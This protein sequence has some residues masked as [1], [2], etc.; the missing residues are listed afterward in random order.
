MTARV[1]LVVA[2]LAPFAGPATA[3]V[4]QLD[5]SADFNADVVVNDGLGMLDPLQEPIDLGNI[6][7]GNFSF[8][9]QTVSDNSAVPPETPDG[10]PDDAFFPAA[11]FHPDVQLSWSNDDD[12]VN[13]WRLPDMTGVIRI[14][15]P[16]GQHVEFHV[17]ATSGNGPTFM[18]ITPIYQDGTGPALSVTVFDWFTDPI[19]NADTYAIVNDLDRMQPGNGPGT[20]FAYSDRDAAA[21]FGFRMLVDPTRELVSVQLER[22]DSFGV[23]NVF[24]ALVVTDDPPEACCFGDGGCAELGPGDC[25]FNGGTPQ[26]PGSDC[27]SAACPQAEAC[28][29]QDGSCMDLL[30]DD[31]RAMAG[32][33]EGPGSDC[34]SSACPQF[35]ACC[36]ADGS[37]VDLEPG[38]CE[39]QD[40]SPLGPGTECFS[41]N[42]AADEACCLDGGLCL[43]L[44]PA[45]CTALD[46]IPQG[47]ATTCAGT[48]CP[49]PTIPGHA[50]NGADRPGVPLT[51]V[52]SG[53]TDLLLSWGRSCSPDAVDTAMHEGSLG[54][55]YSHEAVAC[56]TAGGDTMVSLTPSPQSRYYLV[57]P[58]TATD[59]GSYGLD[60]ARNER[61]ISTAAICVAAQL[62]G[63]P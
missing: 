57:V 35:E 59:E 12:G 62:L 47:P 6:E 21:I 61:P 56:D 54:A 52:K 31:C 20:P 29:F 11:G 9:T 16:L 22:T 34:A 44:R 38:E 32:A 46:G 2:L 15:I 17:F 18:D 37:C 33:P 3:E 14:A 30:A 58:I 51:V 41:S 13:A 53:A 63:C 5:I 42:C 45:E 8:T 10:L 39:L 28:C 1:L 43:D 4:L 27:V 40:G 7:T 50:P 23:L 60:S 26:G 36:F 55:W 25:S 48:A 49:D 19:E 24:G